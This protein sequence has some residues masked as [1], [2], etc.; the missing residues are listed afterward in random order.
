MR[1]PRR[2]SP[3]RPSRH[4]DTLD[5]VWRALANPVRREI[6]DR[7][8]D[9]ALSTGELVMEFPEL[10]RFAVMQHLG[11]LEKA[12]LVIH[13]KV[14]RTR[15]NFINVVPIR[16]IYER[17]VTRYEEYW[18]GSLLDLQRRVEGGTPKGD[19]PGGRLRRISQP[20]TEPSS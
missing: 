1:S 18:A 9:G 2:P 7:L 19:R 17:W 5:G 8:R 20:A 6:L 16:R 11:V 12:G 3:S 10:S 4:A 13:R 14:G 15:L